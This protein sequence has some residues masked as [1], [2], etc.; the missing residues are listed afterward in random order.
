MLANIT[1]SQLPVGVPAR[2][3][4]CCCAE[5]IERLLI[6]A[7]NNPPAAP[8]LEGGGSA[9]VSEP[10]R[11][12]NDREFVNPQKAKYATNQSSQPIDVLTHP[13][14]LVLYSHCFAISLSSARR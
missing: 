14:P 3:S 7:G 9:R 6:A 1:Q 4:H 8:T 11:G 5:L 12:V 10:E 2:M 13:S